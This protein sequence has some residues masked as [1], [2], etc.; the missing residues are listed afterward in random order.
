MTLDEWNV[1][2]CNRARLVIRWR[3]LYFF[4]IEIWCFLAKII[5]ILYILVLLEEYHVVFT[6]VS[7]FNTLY[8][9]SCFI[10]SRSIS[11]PIVSETSII[12]KIC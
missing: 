12:V 9:I 4:I 2:I 3:N 10:L 5:S 6:G 7:I 11:L 1:D 8:I